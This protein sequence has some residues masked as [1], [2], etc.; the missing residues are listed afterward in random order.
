MPFLLLACVTTSEDSARD[1]SDQP[2]DTG[3][4]D[5]GEPAPA[6]LVASVWPPA[7][8]PDSEF[9]GAALDGTE[10]ACSWSSGEVE[11]GTDCRML[12]EASA[13]A[14]GATV[15]LR[16][17]DVADARRQ[18]ETS[19][20]VGQ[21][22]DLA[23]TEAMSGLLSFLDGESGA[24]IEQV[25]L[26]TGYPLP[27]AVAASADG[28]TVWATAHLAGTVSRVE[29]SPR[30]VSAVAELDTQLYWIA[31][32]EERGRLL[33][34][35][36]GTG[37]IAVVDAATLAWTGSLAL[38]QAPVSVRL[39]GDDAWVA[40][41]APESPAGSDG[42]TGS[43][44]PEV[45]AGMVARVSLGDDTVTEVELGEEPYWAEPSPDGSEVAV[46]DEPAGVVYVLDAATM[47]VLRAFEVPGSPTGIAWH[48]V[49]RRLY[50]ALYT[51]ALTVEFDADTGEELRR[52]ETGA[53]SVGVF[54]RDDGRRLYVPAL[55]GN[56]IAVIDTATEEPPAAWTGVTGPR[57]VAFVR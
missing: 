30:A 31:A 5:T 42:D 11:L 16:V 45:R 18:G 22:P 39:S 12:G 37:S 20:T 19:V 49:D 51:E 28:T 35:E 23:V 24:P 33:V 54:S 57:A 6:E 44:E 50:V 14:A 3:S 53:G 15:T 55:H 2:V 56:A 29:G 8:Y 41:R 26:G 13:L 4:A 47:A 9:R 7:P 10:V 48:P 27:I 52:W 32:D 43:P 38:S 17:T 34:A 36:Q 46:A 25:A 1:L 40:A 21:P